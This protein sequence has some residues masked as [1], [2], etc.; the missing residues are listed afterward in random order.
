MLVNTNVATSSD[1]NVTASNTTGIPITDGSFSRSE[2]EKF[3]HV[4]GVWG[5]LIIGHEINQYMDPI[6]VLKVIK[7]FASSLV[8]IYN[9]GQSMVRMPQTTLDDVVKK[10]DTEFKDMK[11][12]LTEI[13]SALQRMEIYT[14]RDV[15]LAV[16]KS[17]SDMAH[18]T[19]TDLATRAIGLY[20]QLFTFLR[21]ILGI[22]TAS[23][24][25]LVT[26]R[27]LYD[28]SLFH[29]IFIVNLFI[30]ITS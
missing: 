22:H 13:A 7:G 14:Y 1:S 30:F 9:M 21:G 6:T 10:I 20:D 29:L 28:V 3:G 12:Q 4:D 8:T 5:K 24:D 15:D 27:N 26:L 25:L 11:T 19:K 16:D 18:K 17:I 2:L 23:P